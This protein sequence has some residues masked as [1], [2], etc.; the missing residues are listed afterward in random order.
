MHTIA[1]CRRMSP[2]AGTLGMWLR[3]DDLLGRRKRIGTAVADINLL[4]LAAVAWAV[5]RR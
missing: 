3:Q 2:C 4:L 1:A 5:A